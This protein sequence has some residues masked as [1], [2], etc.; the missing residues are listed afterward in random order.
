MP[1][2]I[3][4]M[5][6]HKSKELLIK[7]A[8]Q[9]ASACLM[10]Q[11]SPELM[12]DAL[13]NF[14]EEV[15]FAAKKNLQFGLSLFTLNPLTLAPYALQFKQEYRH[16]GD[17]YTH[18]LMKIAELHFSVYQRLIQ[19]PSEQPI[20]ITE[21]LEKLQ[22]RYRVKNQILRLKE[23]LKASLGQYL[24]VSNVKTMLAADVKA[25]KLN[26]KP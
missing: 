6:P 19:L 7:I 21:Q 11:N 17:D 22:D 24:V 18:D 25:S 14:M 9:Q 23:T 5:L 20:L 3:T 10:L 8:K 1:V 12:Q 26:L 15:I 4:T 16:D 2:I 13:E